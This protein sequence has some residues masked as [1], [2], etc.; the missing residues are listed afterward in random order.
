V[1]ARINTAVYNVAVT[2][3]GSA[4]TAGRAEIIETSAP[5]SRVRTVELFLTGL[6]EE[7]A[8]KAILAANSGQPVD[9]RVLGIYGYWT[10]CEIDERRPGLTSFHLKSC[11]EIMAGMLPVA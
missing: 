6:P 8:G 9:V 1:T 11:G 3:D 2:F 4:G 5:R 7:I 10:V